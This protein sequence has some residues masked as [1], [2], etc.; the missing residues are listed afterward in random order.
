MKRQF[1]LCIFNYEKDACRKELL[2]M[3]FKKGKRERERVKETERKCLQGMTLTSALS[4]EFSSIYLSHE[5]YI[6]Q[7]NNDEM[8]NFHHPKAV[9]G[10]CGLKKIDRRRLGGNL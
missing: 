1:V 5:T 7:K 2:C 8:K 9:G 6:T 4:L 3:A 10:G